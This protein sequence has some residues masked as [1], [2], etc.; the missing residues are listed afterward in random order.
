MV[1]PYGYAY[2]HEDTGLQQVVDIQQVEWGFE[3]N[4][5][6]WE[7][8]GP[9]YFHPP[10]VAAAE[11]EIARLEKLNAE[12]HKELDAA[13]ATREACGYHADTYAALLSAIEAIKEIAH[14]DRASL[15]KTTEA[16]KDA[17]NAALEEAAKLIE[18]GFK[19]SHSDEF[20]TKEDKCFHGKYA[21]EDCDVC[22]VAA[23]RSLKS[24]RE[25]K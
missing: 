18:E 24:S 19:R 20:H 4:N 5:P 2:Q 17:R 1:E 6:R 8:I 25:K 9:V 12:L 15:K 7:R 16:L 13:N 23:I 11:T 22:C 10:S 3:K 21:W 14:E